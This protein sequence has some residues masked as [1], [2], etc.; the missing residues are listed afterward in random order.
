MRR[1][2]TALQRE[3]MSKLDRQLNQTSGE[4]TV[5]INWPRGELVNVDQ[6][7]EQLV[8][9]IDCHQYRVPI[10]LRGVHGAPDAL[11]ELLHEAQRYARSQGKLVSISAAL[12]AMQNALSSRQRSIRKPQPTESA[13]DASAVA[14]EL[15]E[16]RY[17]EERKYDIS[18]AEK[19]GDTV[20]RVAKRKRSRRLRLT[21]IAS[22]VVIATLGIAA[23]E[24]LYLTSL[25]SPVT[26]Q[27]NRSLE[28]RSGNN[29]EN[30]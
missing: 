29:V 22:V 5:A 13:G 28:E 7:R 11:V 19:V 17:S 8:N 27:E 1:G 9:E 6:L 15:L 24:W 23:A 18:K 30:P 3:D 16:T 25:D 2:D 26:F 4:S 14:D 10:D 20:S 12:P 21:I